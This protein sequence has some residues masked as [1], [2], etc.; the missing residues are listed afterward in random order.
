MRKFKLHRTGA[1]EV[2]NEIYQIVLPTCYRATVNV[3]STQLFWGTFRYQESKGQHHSVL[4]LAWD[5]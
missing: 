4:L 2:W 5:R 3:F 1:D